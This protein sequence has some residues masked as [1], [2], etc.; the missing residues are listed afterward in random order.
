MKSLPML[1]NLS[2]FEKDELIINLSE[3]NKRLKAENEALKSQASGMALT[4]KTSKNSSIP[5]SK[6]Q[7]ANKGKSKPKKR[8][9]RKQSWAE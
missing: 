6:D 8:Q 9:T 5:P 4:K 2:P 7:K 3:E 1:N